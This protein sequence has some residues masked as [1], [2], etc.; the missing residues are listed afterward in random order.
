[1]SF[2][3][4]EE[5]LQIFQLFLILAYDITKASYLANSLLLF[6]KILPKNVSSKLKYENIVSLRTFSLQFVDSEAVLEYNV[7]IAHL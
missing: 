7:I 5:N 2:C 3:I 1:M 6:E 4:F